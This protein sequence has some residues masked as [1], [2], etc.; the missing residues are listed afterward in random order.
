MS[1]T[2]LLPKPKLE[3]VQR[4]EV[5]TGTG[6]RRASGRA[7]PWP[8]VQ[9]PPRRRSKLATSYTSDLAITNA[10]APRPSN[11]IGLRSGCQIRHAAMLQAAPQ[12]NGRMPA[13]SSIT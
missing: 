2:E 4:L 13:D 12:A 1:D 9:N 8:P 10:A 5:F 11:T 3:P 6:R 7:S